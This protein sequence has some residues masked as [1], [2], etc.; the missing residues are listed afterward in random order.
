MN[1]G[2]DQDDAGQ[3]ASSAGAASITKAPAIEDPASTSAGSS[4]TSMNSRMSRA[5]LAMVWPVAGREDRPLP[6][7]STVITRWSWTRSGSCAPQTRPLVPQPCRKT[8]GWPAPWYKSS[9][10]PSHMP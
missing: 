6:R 3:P 10:S 9:V 8:R 4:S 7:Q 1:A 5:T 2:I